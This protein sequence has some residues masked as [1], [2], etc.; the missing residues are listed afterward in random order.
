MVWVIDG[1]IYGFF[2]ALYTL[3]NQEYKIN[4]YLL[5][6]WR[7]FGISIVFFPFIYFLPV[8]T[9]AYYWGLLI[10]QGWMM[11]FYDSHLF[12]SSAN[13]G[14]GPTS[15]IMALA[16]LVTTIIWWLITP[17]E[18]L[19]L[20]ND[21]T[22]FITLILILFG[23]TISYW[24]M[25]K[26]QVSKA[27]LLYM[28]PVVLAFSGMSIITKAIAIHGNNVWVSVLY[29]L[30]V[31]TFVSG[32]YNTYFYIKREKVG[33][34]KFIKNVFAWNVVKAGAY[35][36]SFSAALIVAKTLSLRESPN[37][38]YVVA[39]VLTSPIFVFWINKYHKIPDDVSVKAGF[40]MI[41]CL[42]LLLLL[43]N[44]NYGVLD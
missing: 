6:V 18:F 27:V 34:I 16:A 14:A 7:G 1:L 29:Y 2:M 44:G 20:Y 43:V 38:G 11:G 31:V 15:R 19:K 36:I 10:L 22:L 35:V 17:S 8:P 41:F 12:F 3:V 23:F 4:G 9:N 32:C 39:L 30:V 24:Y 28:A 13:Y 5:G 42:V 37:P 21:G 26:D 33:F 40:S 25:I